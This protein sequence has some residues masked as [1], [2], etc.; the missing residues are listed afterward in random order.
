[1]LAR[2]LGGTCRTI[3][4][5][6]TGRH[7]HGQ[8]GTPLASNAVGHKGSLRLHGLKKSSGICM[9]KVRGKSLMIEGRTR[10]EKRAL[11]VIQIRLF[12]HPL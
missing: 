6:R 3:E 10:R 7:H 12:T 2:L 5:A 8:C 11:F 9:M 1:M 4:I